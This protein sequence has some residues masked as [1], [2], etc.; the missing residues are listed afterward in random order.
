MIDRMLLHVRTRFNTKR[1]MQC[2]YDITMWRG[3]ITIVAVKTQQ[4]IVCVC[5]CC[6]LSFTGNYKNI[7]CCTTTM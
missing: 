3:R 1:D 7:D 2:T 6:S 4:R 5:V